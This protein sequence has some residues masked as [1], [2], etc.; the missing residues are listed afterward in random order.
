MA[1]ACDASTWEVKEGGSEIQ[2]HPRL[3]GELKPSQYGLHE[4]LSQ[5]RQAGRQAADWLE[6]IHK[7]RN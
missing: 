3:R 7:D 4:T 2:G 5:R 1:R 6:G